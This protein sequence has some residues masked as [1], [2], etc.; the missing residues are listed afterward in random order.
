[1]LLKKILKFS[2][3]ILV[4]FF[5]AQSFCRCEEKNPPAYDFTLNDLKGNE[6]SLS[7]FRGKNEVVL[8]FWNTR[9]SICESELQMLPLAYDELK[10]NN[11]EL[12]AI[13]LGDT[14]RRTER[15]LSNYKVD[16]TVLL[17]IDGEVAYEYGIYGVPLYIWVD[18]EGFIK[19]WGHRIS[20]IQNKLT[21][22]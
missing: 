21:S 9:C 6:V 12:L 1:M 17:D 8:F 19:F 7:D 15:Y 2:F 22:N 10:K 14:R 18:K 5:W 11:I 16:Y 4:L 13:D 20:Q 3:L